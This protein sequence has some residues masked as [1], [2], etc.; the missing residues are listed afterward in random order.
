MTLLPFVSGGD[1]SLPALGLTCLL[2]CVMLLHISVVA[3]VHVGLGYHELE[4]AGDSQSP[5][6]LLIHRLP[7]WREPLLYELPIA[8]ITKGQW[9]RSVESGCLHPDHLLPWTQ[10]GTLDPTSRSYRDQAALV[11][12]SDTAF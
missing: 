5:P 2:A 4:V 6:G 1:L 12:T 10:D 3:C 8:A 11:F 7:G 9:L